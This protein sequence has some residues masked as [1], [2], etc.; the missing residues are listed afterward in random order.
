M[1]GRP[2]AEGAP[3]ETEDDDVSFEVCVF[4]VLVAW[5]AGGAMRRDW[6]DCWL[7]V[8]DLVLALV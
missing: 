4:V 8:L 3:R 5:A 7:D 6:P 2:G 1:S